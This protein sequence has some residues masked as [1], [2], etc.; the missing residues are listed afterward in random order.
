MFDA[1]LVYL[2]YL[3]VFQVQASLT[4]TLFFVYCSCSRSYIVGL[5][6]DDYVVVVVTL[7]ED[8]IFIFAE[9]T[10]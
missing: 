7:Q 2:G 8:F 6:L 9:F 3:A 10:A 4:F 1:H 5:R